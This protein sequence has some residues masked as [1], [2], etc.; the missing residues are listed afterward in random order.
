MSINKTAGIT[1][2][3][4]AAMFLIGCS[5]SQQLQSSSTRNR[6]RDPRFLDDITLEG[7]GRAT[8]ET[9]ASGGRYRNRRTDAPINGQ[10]LQR[11]YSDMLGITPQ[12]IENMPLYS[13][14]EDWYGVPY[15]LGGSDKNGTDCSGF[16]QRLYEQVFG[17]NLLRT[18]VEQF[19]NCRMVWDKKDLHEGDLVFFRTHGKRISHVGIYLANNFFVHASTS[20]GVV[21]S[22]LDEDY[23]NRS[24]AGA[25]QVP[26]SRS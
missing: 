14:I 22:S 17:T 9:T 7:G 20:K 4:A 23:W 11:K 10:G 16:V 25:G 1:T 13:F 24:Y 8:V 15:R 5:S 12:S 26:R 6:S 19:N 18:S 2:W 3:L 21:I